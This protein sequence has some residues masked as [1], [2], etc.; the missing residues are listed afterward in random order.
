VARHTGRGEATL[1]AELREAK[2]GGALD[3]F[4]SACGRGR[5]WERW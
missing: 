4:L 5:G 1:G 2:S 3:A